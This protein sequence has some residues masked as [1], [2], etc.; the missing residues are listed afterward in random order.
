MSPARSCAMSTSS[1]IVFT[2]KT[3]ATG[4]SDDTTTRRDAST[5]IGACGRKYARSRRSAVRSDVAAMS[6]VLTM[7]STGSIRC[8]DLVVETR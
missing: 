3:S 5:S 6:G 4:T 7:G 2:R 8:D 1:S